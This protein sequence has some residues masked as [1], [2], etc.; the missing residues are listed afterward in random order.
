MT[1]PIK[2]NYW[3]L[4]RY[5]SFLFVQDY[6][7]GNQAQKKR[8][9]DRIT[10]RVYQKF[11]IYILVARLAYC[12][13]FLTALY[14]PRDVRLRQRKCHRW[15]WAISDLQN[16]EYL[17]AWAEDDV[18]DSVRI[19]ILGT[20]SVGDVLQTTPIIRALR[21]KLPR[22]KICLLHRCPV[23]QIILQNNQNVGSVARADFHHF[24]AIKHAVQ[25]EGIADL[26]V[27]IKNISF[28]ITYMRPPTHLRRP[29]VTKLLPDEFFATAESALHQWQK[30]LP[31][32]PREDGKCSWPKE[33]QEFHILDVMGM[34]GNLAINRYSN[35]DFYCDPKAESIITKLPT[36]G[37]IITVQNG[38]DT[39]VTNWSRV[40][41][42]RATKLLPKPTWSL[43]A[44]LLQQKGFTVVQLGTTD[45]DVIDGVSLDLRG[46]TSLHEAAVIMKRAVCNIGT[47]GGLVH[48]GRAVDAK[49]VV[50]FGPTSL[51][52]L[53]Y[54][55]NINLTSSDCNSCFWI[56]S[57]WYILCPRGLK[58]PECMYSYRAETIVDA[59]T[60]A[61]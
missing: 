16:R 20:G 4:L 45:D 47:E 43:V 25:N 8:F 32:F 40:L 42:R 31:V 44:R 55:Q 3:Q 30:K 33:W 22:A 19:I 27:E 58:E 39:D 54:P 15:L 61:A 36:A 9:I 56:T 34:T 17:A 21:E 6:I 48:L 29:F 35:L 41:K 2:K 46:Q 10:Q 50:L 13:S 37:R 14:K 49:M 24:T 12:L 60:R 23:A 57:D 26:I 11:G 51:T 53:G 52:F 38:V 18:T 7:H 28:I 5:I 1:Q 59:A